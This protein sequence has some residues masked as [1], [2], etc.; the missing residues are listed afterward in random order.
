M[1][2]EHIVAAEI[3]GEWQIGDSEAPFVLDDIPSHHRE[4]IISDVQFSERVT[5]L[6]LAELVL[7]SLLLQL[8]SEVGDLV[9]FLFQGVSPIVQIK[10][11]VVDLFIEIE[12]IP[13]VFVHLAFNF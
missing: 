7:H 6:H 8:L 11:V 9:I 5:E 12:V 2:R 3:P 13:V 4:V 10:I 1:E